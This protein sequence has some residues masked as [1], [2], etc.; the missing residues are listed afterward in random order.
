MLLIWDI[1]KTF[2][3]K[4]LKIR[5]INRLKV[6]A[7]LQKNLSTDAFYEKEEQKLL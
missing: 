5:R 6:V 7:S 2:M 4:I 3:S 1:E